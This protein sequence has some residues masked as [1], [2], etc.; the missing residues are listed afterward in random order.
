MWRDS[1]EFDKKF[2][3]GQVIKIKGNLKMNL[4]TSLG[5]LFTFDLIGLL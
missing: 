1:A 5:N 2:D 4:L 3:K